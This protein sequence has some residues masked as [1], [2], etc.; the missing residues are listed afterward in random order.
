MIFCPSSNGDFGV[1]VIVFL[2]FGSTFISPG[3]ETVV[4][5]FVRIVKFC[6]IAVSSK[7]LLKVAVIGIF[8]STFVAFLGIELSNTK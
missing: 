3:I 8:L 4:P 7:S 1:K 2:L 5:S 6:V